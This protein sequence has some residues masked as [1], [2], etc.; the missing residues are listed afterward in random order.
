MTKKGPFARVFYYAASVFGFFVSLVSSRKSATAA[1][2]DLC[3]FWPSGTTATPLFTVSGS[4]PPLPV[5]AQ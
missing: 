2:T 5:M 3:P 4:L 1:A